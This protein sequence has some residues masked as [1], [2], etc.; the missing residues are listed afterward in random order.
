MYKKEE[1]EGRSAGA[2]GEK[3]MQ[4]GVVVFVKKKESE[5]NIK[6]PSRRKIDVP[7]YGR[8]RMLRGGSAHIFEKDEG[9]GSFFRT[10][11]GCN[12]IFLLRSRRRRRP[13]AA[14]P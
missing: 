6:T 3:K 9:R 1:E 14:W 11:I 4:G 12:I 5:R 10:L 8:P 13:W 2:K 7:F